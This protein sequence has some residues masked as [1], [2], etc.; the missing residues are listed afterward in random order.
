MTYNNKLVH[1]STR[2]T[3]NDARK[4]Q[5][6]LNVYLNMELKA[7]HNRKYPEINIVDRVFIYMKRKANQQS[8]VSL[9]FD[10]SY[11]VESISAA[12]GTTFYI[13]TARDKQFLRHELLK[14]N[15]K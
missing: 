6:E 8:H 7:K 11:E 3:P 10:V 1:S 12:H 5:N 14:H 2:F 4:P 9:W 15:L 13:T